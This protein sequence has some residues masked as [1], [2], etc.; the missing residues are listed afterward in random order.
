LSGELQ[1][2]LDEYAHV[3]REWL[4]I[5]DASSDTIGRLLGQA[6]SDAASVRVAS[7]RVEDVRPNGQGVVKV[8][9]K[10][11][12]VRYALRLRAQSM[13]EIGDVQ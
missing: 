11:L 9:P 1:A 2:V 5:I 12:R 13:E 6:I 8:E 10:N 4:G 7:D 3:L